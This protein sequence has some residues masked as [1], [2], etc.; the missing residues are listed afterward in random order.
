M[1]LVAVA[2]GSR[3]PRSA[4]TVGELLAVVRDRRPGL[5]VKG[6]FLDLSTPRLLDV[7]TA[8]HRE[9]HREVVV[10]PLLLGRAFHARVDLPALLEEAH[11]RLPMLRTSVADVLGPDPGLEAAALRRLA[12]VGVRPGAP[13]VG[14]VLAATGSSHAPANARVRAIAERWAHTQGWSGVRAAFASAADPDVPSAVAALRA[15]GARRIAVASYFLAPGL[16]PDRVR[17]QA[18]TAAVVAEPLGAAT[19]VADV[20]LDRY[21]LAS[22]DLG[23]ARSA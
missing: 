15:R 9:G 7:L 18:G 16:L 10:A 22:Q 3:D 21:D 2:H 12:E 19:E 1:P 20:V 4:T 14:V 8:L 17:A 13:G 5:A 23:A 6:A 11:E